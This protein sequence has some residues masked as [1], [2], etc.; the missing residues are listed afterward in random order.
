MTSTAMFTI[1]NNMSIMVLAAFTRLG[2]LKI[3][4]TAIMKP[5]VR[6][7]LTYGVP[8][9]LDTFCSAPGS[10]P[11]RLMAMGL[12][13]AAR[14]P[15][16]AVVMKA[17]IAPAESMIMPHWPRN[18]LAARLK[19]TRLPE[20]VFASSTPTVVKTAA[21]YSSITTNAAANIP[22]GRFRPGRRTSSA[23]DA[24]FVSPP[25]ATKTIPA[26]ART[27]A[28][29]LPMKSSKCMCFAAGRPEETNIPSTPNNAATITI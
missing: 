4:I 5:L 7:M 1:T 18:S 28:I 23:T 26:V 12:L 14:M 13:E 19:G 6:R 2:M 21:T 25:K 10:S 16:L 11:S 9:R 15:L 20:S 8:N 24:T 22:A 17:S 29:P 3:P 27:L